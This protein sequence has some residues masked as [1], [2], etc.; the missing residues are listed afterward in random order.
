[1]DELMKQLI[2]IGLFS[3]NGYITKIVSGTAI[4]SSRVIFQSIHNKMT[5]APIMEKNPKKKLLSHKFFDDIRILRN[6]AHR[7]ARFMG[8][9]IRQA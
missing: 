5:T 3:P 2:L 4:S 6:A 1:M 9:V 7:F 8:I